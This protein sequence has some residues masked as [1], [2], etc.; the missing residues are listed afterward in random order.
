MTTLDDVIDAATRMVT[1]LWEH[2]LA[3]DPS[4]RPPQFYVFTLDGGMTPDQHEIAVFNGIGSVGML[5][6]VNER[7]FYDRR[8]P[9][10]L[11]E[12]TDVSFTLRD[13]ARTFSMTGRFSGSFTDGGAWREIPVEVDSTTGT[14]PAPGTRMVLSLRWDWGA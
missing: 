13:L 14:L 4:A 10:L 9:F 1:L 6:R 8:L 3:A 12:T 7:D 5:L 11:L 2:D